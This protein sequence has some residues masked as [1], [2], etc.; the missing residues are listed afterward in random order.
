[1]D[2]T[3]SLTHQAGFDR[4]SRSGLAGSKRG[5]LPASNYLSQGEGGDDGC[6]AEAVTHQEFSIQ[7]CTNRMSDASNPGKL[8]TVHPLD[9]F[10]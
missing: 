8:T 3:T 7:R 2:F 1:M 10:E 9:I 4:V 5:S 6:F